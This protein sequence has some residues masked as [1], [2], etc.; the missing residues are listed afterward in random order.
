MPVGMAQSLYSANVTE[1]MKTTKDRKRWRNIMA[2]MPSCIGA[3]DD[4]NI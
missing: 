4:D 3:H 1:I 2:N